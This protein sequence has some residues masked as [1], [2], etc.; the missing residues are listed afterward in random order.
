MSTKCYKRLIKQLFKK[1]EK[2]EKK[3]EKKK[4]N[5]SVRRRTDYIPNGCAYKKTSERFDNYY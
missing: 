3:K 2:I 5:R 1:S 4:I